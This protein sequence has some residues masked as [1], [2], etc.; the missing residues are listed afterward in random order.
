MTQETKWITTWEVFPITSWNVGP[1]VP[2]LWLLCLHLIWHFHVRKGICKGSCSKISTSFPGFAVATTSLLLTYFWA[3][4]RRWL[5]YGSTK[6]TCY[7]LGISLCNSNGTW[8]LK[9]LLPSWNFPLQ[10]QGDLASRNLILKLVYMM[11]EACWKK[12]F[13]EVSNGCRMFILDSV[14]SCWDNDKSISKTL[15]ISISIFDGSTFLNT[16]LK[17]LKIW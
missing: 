12:N 5:D 2:I 14:W 11:M 16:C 9:N 4:P 17:V 8:R 13:R 10:F 7:L 6:K 15:E 3:V 1:M